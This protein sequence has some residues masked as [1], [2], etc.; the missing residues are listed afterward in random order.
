MRRRHPLRTLLVGALP[1]LLLCG[2]QRARQAKDTEESPPFVFRSLDLRQQDPQGHPAWELTSPEARYDL[3]RSIAR[4]DRPRGVIYA[5]GQPLYHLQAESGT[6]I[7]DG[8]AILLEG[9]LRMERLR[10]PKVLIEA[11]R[12][13]WLPRQKLLLVDHSPRAY[14]R[15]GRL[16]ADRARFRFDSDTLE[17]TG[18]PRDRKSTRLN[19]SH[20]SV[21]RMPSSA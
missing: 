10:E 14:D 3:G 19:S 15:Q 17:L 21:S 11:P 8:E 13:R 16:N 18:S 2:C 4:A 1:L 20:S 5:G 6:V 12:A 7:S 9:K